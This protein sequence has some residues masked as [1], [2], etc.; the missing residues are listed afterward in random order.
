MLCLLRLSPFNFHSVLLLLLLLQLNVGE[1]ASPTTKIITLL[2]FFNFVSEVPR[3]QYKWT[4]DCWCVWKSFGVN[5]CLQW[6][7]YFHFIEEIFCEFVEVILTSH[8]AFAP[9]IS[10]SRDRIWA[11]LSLPRLALRTEKHEKVVYVHYR[12][13]MCRECWAVKRNGHVCNKIKDIMPLSPIDHLRSYCHLV[14]FDWTTCTC[15]VYPRDNKASSFSK[16]FLWFRGSVHRPGFDTRLGSVFSVLYHFLWIVHW[17]LAF[18]AIQ[19]MT[20]T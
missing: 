8:G 11:L 19:Q 16:K 18:I 14:N 15:T 6:R 5:A 1:L 3:L 4:S 20:W 12:D 2:E 10:I 17:P 7:K 13:I 9:S